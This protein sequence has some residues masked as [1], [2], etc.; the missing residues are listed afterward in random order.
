MHNLDEMTR[1]V[2]Y[3]RLTSVLTFK[4]IGEIVGKS[5]TWQ[6]LLFTEENKKL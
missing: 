6:G 2:M 3:L 1:E 5:E 4:E